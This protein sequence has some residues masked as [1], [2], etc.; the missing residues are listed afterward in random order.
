MFWRLH[1]NAKKP[2][3]TKKLGI[4]VCTCCPS[5][6][7]KGKIGETR[8]RPAWAKTRPYLKNNQSTKGWR[9]GSSYREP[10]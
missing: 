4:V 3:K 10:A 7:E 6:G 5:Y 9:H 1:L 2:P 8:S